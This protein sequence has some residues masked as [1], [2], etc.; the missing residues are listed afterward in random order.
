[1]SKDVS[2]VLN[3]EGGEHALI[4]LKLEGERTQREM[5][6]NQGLPVDPL[7]GGLLHLDLMEVP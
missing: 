3:I 1:V 4:N 7:S 5:A 2:K 6:L